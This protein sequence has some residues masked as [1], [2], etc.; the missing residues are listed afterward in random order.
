MWD[1]WIFPHEGKFFLYWLQNKFRRKHWDSIGLA[2]SD[3][4]LRWREIGTIIEKAADAKWMGTGRTWK[5]GDRF[6]LNF[7]EERRGLQAIYFAESHN[8]LDWKRLGPEYSSQPDP[9]WYVT[10]LS[11]TPQDGVRWDCLTPVRLQDGEYIGFLTAEAKSSPPGV[12]AIIGAM[13]SKDGMHWRAAP[14]ASQRTAPIAEPSG[15]ARFGNRHY[16]FVQIF[17]AIGPRYD[18]F[19]TGPQGNGMW[20]WCSSR[21][22]GPYTPPLYDHLLHGQRSS[23]YSAWFG[24]SFRHQEKWLWNHHWTG[25]QGVVRLGTLKELIED[26]P[27]HL[28]LLYWSGNE[29]LKGERVVAPDQLPL[30]GYP[31]PVRDRPL[32]AK[33]QVGTDALEGTAEWGNGL[34]VLNI[35][36]VAKTG[37]ML[38]CDL[39]VT[40]NT[41]DGAGLFVGGKEDLRADGITLLLEPQ[42]RATLGRTTMGRATPRF[43]F[44]ESFA[45]RSFSDGKVRLRAIVWAEFVEIYADDRLLRTLTLRPGESFNGSIGVWIDRCRAS[46]NHLEVWSLRH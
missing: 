18:P 28:A 5:V 10:Q 35:P 2:E 38:T 15:Y 13:R 20:Y 24:T 30:V 29:G 22:E 25:T 44:W 37:C 45:T 32:C 17:E 4:L 1:T 16:V 7:S 8:L 31:Q 27:F 40:D 3:D 19:S 11:E 9:R 39:S 46:L 26:A 21:A 23:D 33:W 12:S 36:H 43:H 41:G 42:G 6:L 34:A 14:P